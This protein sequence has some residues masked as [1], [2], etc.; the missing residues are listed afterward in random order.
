MLLVFFLTSL[1]ST[2]S[3]CVQCASVTLFNQWQLT[4]FARYPANLPFTPRCAS[5]ED[6]DTLSPTMNVT[7]CSSV[8]FEMV[9]PFEHSFITEELDELYL[10][11][12]NPSQL[13]GLV[14]FVGVDIE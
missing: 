9:I 1:P 5:V 10:A 8:C 4:G 14:L 12:K 7:Q 2:D 13:S 11:K 3:W 6:D